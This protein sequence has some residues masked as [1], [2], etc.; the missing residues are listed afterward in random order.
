MVGNRIVV[1]CTANMI[2][3]PFIAGLLSSRLAA[4]TE[5]RLGIESA[6]TAA[7]PG[8]QAAPDEA[9]CGPPH[10]QPTASFERNERIIRASSWT[11]PSS[12]VGPCIARTVFSRT[13]R[14][15]TSPSS[16]LPAKPGSRPLRSIPCSP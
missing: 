1:V 12:W 10:S 9:R 8:D 16:A 2:R 14:F 7:R 15:S 6:G 5:G 11:G 4:T 3:S 13:A